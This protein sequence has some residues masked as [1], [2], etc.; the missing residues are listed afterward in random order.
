MH[1]RLPQTGPLGT[2]RIQPIHLAWIGKQ[3]YKTFV[4]DILKRFVD[5]VGTLSPVA[6]L[7]TI[8]MALTMAAMS[9]SIQM[10]MRG[11]ISEEKRRR[12]IK[13]NDSIQSVRDFLSS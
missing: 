5:F 8:T 7:A 3:G 9:L 12:L 2:Y 13:T 6:F 1:F 10:R 4:S 11:P